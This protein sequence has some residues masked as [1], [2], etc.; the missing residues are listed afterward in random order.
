MAALWDPNNVFKV[1]GNATGADIQC[2]GARRDG[3]RCGWQKRSGDPD[4]RNALALVASMATRPPPNVTTADLR[5][6]AKY[7]LCRDWHANQ[8]DRIVREWQHV[9]KQAVDRYNATRKAA[10]LEASQPTPSFHPVLAPQFASSQTLTNG[11]RSVGATQD[12]RAEYI[13]Q[14][15]K[16]EGL[17]SALKMDKTKF[18]KDLAETQDKV[19]VLEVKNKNLEQQCRSLE[20]EEALKISERSTLLKEHSKLKEEASNMPFFK[21]EITRLRKDNDSL[22][23]EVRT[24][25]LDN[26]SLTKR[27]EQL[28]DEKL[29]NDTTQQGVEELRKRL[30]R[31]KTS[32]EEMRRVNQQRDA[33]IQ[34]LR[35]RLREKDAESAGSQRQ[36]E[37]EI[38]QA[39][40][41]L[42]G[43]E[44]EKERLVTEN[45]ELRQRLQGVL[46]SLKEAEERAQSVQPGAGPV[47]VWEPHG[48]N[49]NDRSSWIRRLEK[50]LKELGSA[51]TRKVSRI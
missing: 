20:E 32:R 30:S 1:S 35:Q 5:S 6:L 42:V 9:L 33:E 38:L 46:A 24:I 14:I 18:A 39:R 29:H 50:W 43:A 17:L 22:R 26:E 28:E 11:S 27:C 48:R 12:D 49:R 51:S 44:L 10:E 37:A 21:S 40:E 3:D 2:R 36:R 8:Q 47:V 31:S 25:K 13:Q 4:A 41:Q 34:E 7:C 45:S 15:Q 19:S 23:G 16:L